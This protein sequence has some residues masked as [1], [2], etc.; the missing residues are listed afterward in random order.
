MASFTHYLQGATPTEISATDKL[1]LA[2]GAFA[3]KITVDDYNTSTHVKTDADADKSSANTPRNN[4]FVAAGTV[5]V[6]G[7]TAINVADATTANCTLK[8]TFDGD[9]GDVETENGKFYAYDGTTPATAPTGMTVQ[10]AEPG[11][12]EWKAVGGSAAALDLGD[13]S[14]AAAT[15]D[16][17]LLVSAKPTAVGEKSGKYWIE[18]DYF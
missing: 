10:A 9:A 1:W 14:S 13:N 3:T 12:A 7:N 2:G 4:M 6:D 18:L 11:N 15:H 16:F 17:Y 8:I 5:S